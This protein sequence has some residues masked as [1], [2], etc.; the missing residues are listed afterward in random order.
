[1]KPA[2]TA[3]L[4]DVLIQP[5]CLCY[6]EDDVTWQETVDGHGLWPVVVQ[7]KELCQSDGWPD[8]DDVRDAVVRGTWLCGHVESRRDA[9]SI[10]LDSLNG[11]LLGMQALHASLSG[12]RTD[13]PT[14]T[15]ESARSNTDQV[16][17]AIA[18][19]PP[20]SAARITQAVREGTEQHQKLAN[21]ALD[22]LRVEVGSIRAGIA[23][24]QA[25]WR[26]DAEAEV[27]AATDA[28]SKLQSEV[29]TAVTEL[30]SQRARLD[31]ALS[32][33]AA[34][35]QAAEKERVVAESEAL[36]VRE[37]TA[38]NL[39][40]AQEA[41]GKERLQTMDELLAQARTTLQTIGKE[42]SASHYG[43]YADEQRSAAFWWS[44]IVLGSLAGAAGF[45]AW[46]AVEHVGTWH[47]A[48]AR[49]ALGVVFVGAAT[50]AG[51]QSAHHR[52][53]E[54][55][56]R[57]RELAIGALGSFLADVNP[58]KVQILKLGAAADLFIDDGIPDPSQAA[59]QSPSA[60]IVEAI[61]RLVAG[62]EAAPGA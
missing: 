56:A 18:A 51:R 17:S 7:V 2:T 8:D 31:T 46:A 43:T 9:N 10:T 30:A 37:Q 40:T 26:T 1:M 55:Q 13:P 54:R 6:L 59:Y 60:Q 36:K 28:N 16:L 49:Y 42:A 20:P 14:A 32:D 4:S 34:N 21:E 41:S 62:D 45:L 3:M 15:Y 27:Q 19:W 48:A 24:E 25:Q 23:A 29:A 11:G 39:L 12:L 52:A 5:N 22:G 50:Y 57:Q 47:S 44:M 38:A 61:R 35:S 58:E 53:L 33:F